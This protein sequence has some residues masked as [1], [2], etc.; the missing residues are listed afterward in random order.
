[1]V[2]DCSVSHTGALRQRVPWPAFYVAQADPD[3][4]RPTL[5]IWAGLQ[6]FL[7]AMNSGC[8][9]VPDLSSCARR[10]ALR[11]KLRK[12]QAG[13]RLERHRDRAH[14]VASS[15]SL[16]AT[17]GG[18]ANSIP[19]NSFRTAS[20]SAGWLPIT[21]LSTSSSGFRINERS[22]TGPQPLPPVCAPPCAPWPAHRP[23]DPARAAP[24]PPAS[25]GCLAARS[26]FPLP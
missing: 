14:S 3:P 12:Q 25:R 20:S 26:K 11:P 23:P 21:P 6:I 19:A 13:Q 4:Q 18:T 16:P 7:E 8:R 2:G 17:I 22:I 1:M 15:P 24:A 5:G 10:V 9:V